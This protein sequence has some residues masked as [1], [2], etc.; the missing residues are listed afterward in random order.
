MRLKSAL[1]ALLLSVL[2]ATVGHAETLKDAPAAEPAASLKAHWTALLASGCDL[3]AAHVRTTIEAS[4]LRNTPYAL[5]GYAFKAAEL[6]ALFKADGGWYVPDPAVKAPTFTPEE[7]ACIKKLK[8]LEATLDAK[9]A[10][11]A[12]FKA[13][14]LADHRNVMDLR[15]HTRLMGRGVVKTTAMGSNGY[16]LETTDAEVREVQLSCE[17]TECH[18]LVPGGM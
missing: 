14:Y 5:K 4:A 11:S 6:T 3:E 8:T 13:Q 10:I 1:S 18:L 17:A 16:V 9:V 12:K 2:A 7:S 15:G